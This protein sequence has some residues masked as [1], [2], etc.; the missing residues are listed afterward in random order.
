[1]S[2]Q[3]AKTYGE[4]DR[5]TFNGIAGL[6]D[7][8]AQLVGSADTRLAGLLPDGSVDG[9]PAREALKQGL[10]RRLSETAAKARAFPEDR[11]K[12]GPRRD[13]DGGR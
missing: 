6:F 2:R 8:A 3:F 1:M 9:T 13:V 10:L 11:H 4:P 7:A 5:E 12:V